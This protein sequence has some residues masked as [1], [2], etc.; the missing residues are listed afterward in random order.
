MLGAWPVSSTTL[1][2]MD[3]KSIDHWHNSV[4]H[5][6]FLVFVIL[7]LIFLVVQKI[8]YKRERHSF[9]ALLHRPQAI[10]Q[11][12]Q[13]LDANALVDLLDVLRGHFQQADGERVF[14]AF[15]HDS[16]DRIFGRV[17]QSRTGRCQTWTHD[18][19]AR[20]NEAYRSLVD[21]LGPQ[22]ERILVQQAKQWNVR[23]RVA[24]TK[25][26]GLSERIGNQ[27]DVILALDQFGCVFLR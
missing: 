27:F 16:A 6:I 8:E 15:G 26:Q 10:V 18:V 14:F 2:D 24:K 5:V 12:V 4:E 20:E 3:L 11:V 23:L 7:E 21:L 9:E 17:A 25:E 22:D 1:V 13:G 19:G